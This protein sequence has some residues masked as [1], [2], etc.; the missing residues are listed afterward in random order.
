[1]KRSV[2]F[3]VALMVTAA[4]FGQ[5]RQTAGEVKL[6]PTQLMEEFNPKASNSRNTN[7]MFILYG[8][9]EG[10]IYG[11]ELSSFI[12]DL[13][14]DA[15]SADLQFNHV[16]VSYPTL[17]AFDDVNGTSVV[18]WSNV[19]NC[20]IDTVWIQMGHE[21]NSGTT[22]T[23]RVRIVDLNNSGRPTNTVLWEEI[24]TTDTS[25]TGGANWTNSTFRPFFPDI[26]VTE[27]FG[28][29]VD[30]FGSKLDTFGIV[31]SFYED[32]ICTGTTPKALESLFATNSWRQLSQYASF[33]L[34]PTTS[35]ADIYYD[36]NQNGGYDQGIDGEH[37]TQNINFGVSLT[38]QDDISV[39]ELPNNL[40]EVK[41][42]PN[43][44][45]STTN[46]E[47]TLESAS[48]VSLNVFDL[49][50]AMIYSSNKGQQMPGTHTIQI[51]GS[52]MAEGI[53][54]YTLNVNGGSVTKK[55]VLTR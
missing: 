41:N 33:G 20:T 24:I 9:T 26:N 53:Y 6:T 43:P 54:Y 31:A 4:A 14:S 34:L 51:D 23:V 45:S 18:P 3:A 17:Q 52:G 7:E 11:E 16:I 49:T 15:D 42:Y 25:F 48:E 55:M 44:F 35:G 28:V 32:G 12:W 2:L 29:R 46:V 8:S 27:P 5:F 19:V 22:D 39:Q 37:F 21:N 30:Y 13:H 47:Y 10:E 36:C 40:V 38:I 1:M 50:G